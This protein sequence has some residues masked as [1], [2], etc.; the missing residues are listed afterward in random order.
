MRHPA[1][2]VSVVL[3]FLPI[4]TVNDLRELAAPG[5]VA[6][7]LRKYLQAEVQRRMAISK[8]NA[9]REMAV[10]YESPAKP[11]DQEGSQ[12]K[13]NGGKREGSPDGDRRPEESDDE[14]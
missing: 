4:L 5:I 2:P 12:E 11:Q 8:R 6:E 1:K 10:P 13:Q 7:N 3:G 9:S 14:A